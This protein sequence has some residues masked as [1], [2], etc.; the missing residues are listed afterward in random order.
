MNNLEKAK[1]VFALVVSTAT[2]LVTL[3]EIWKR[4]APEVKKAVKPVYEGC[5]KI[6][7]FKQNTPKL[8]K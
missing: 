6:A 2:A 4:I 8:I 7:D 1:D 5:K 3:S